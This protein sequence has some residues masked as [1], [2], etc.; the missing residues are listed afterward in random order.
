M[1]VCVCVCVCVEGASAGGVVG[2]VE[3]WINFSFF[4]F[5]VIFFFLLEY[6]FT[7][8][9]LHYLSCIFFVVILY[10]H[11]FRGHAIPLFFSLK[12][13]KMSQTCKAHWVCVDQSC[14][15][16][17]DLFLLLLLLLFGVG[18]DWGQ[19]WGWGGRGGGGA[20]GK[21]VCCK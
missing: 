13:K 16:K 5:N 18:V 21:S 17:S 20:R 7:H 9:H 8:T 14:C 15:N 6:C 10:I 11:Y 4:L 1:C 3:L 19:G 12:V 2:G